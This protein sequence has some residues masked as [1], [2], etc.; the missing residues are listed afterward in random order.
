MGGIMCRAFVRP[1]SKVAAIAIC[2]LL[3]TAFA[4]AG[5]I[6]VNSL[7]DDVFPDGTGAIFDINGSPITLSS[8]KCTLRMA[9]SAANL[10]VAVGGVPNGCTAG[11]GA[12]VIVFA[13]ALNLATTPGTISIANKL[14][15]EA[16][17]TFSGSDLPS[18]LV[19]S[20]P[21]TITGP[22]STQ[23]TLDGLT[24]NPEG[25]RMLVAADGDGNTDRPFSLS[26][27]R[28][29]RGRV[30]GTGAGCMA[31]TE[32]LTLNDVVFED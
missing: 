31:S 5:T 10:D 23:L 30:P 25:L 24:T 29:Y 13:A 14:M 4:Q 3:W 6:T 15:S 26:G 22:G 20:R 9:I 18:A 11:S 32:S 7:A 17:A 19:V 21:L 2:S 12:D 27:V 8:P 1:T 16:P 28:F